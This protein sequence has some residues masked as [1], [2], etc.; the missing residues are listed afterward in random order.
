MLAPPPAGF[1]GLASPESGRH[2]YTAGMQQPTA[3]PVPR[4]GPFWARALHGL[5]APRLAIGL[6]L[7]FVL[8][9]F[10]WGP[11][12]YVRRGLPL[13]TAALYL[14]L[15]FLARAVWLVPTV[16]L[17]LAAYNLTSGWQKPRR[18][19]LVALVLAAACFA[20]P[21]TFWIDAIAYLGSLDRY[22]Y[23]WA[24]WMYSYV[25][26]GSMLGMLILVTRDQE[27]ARELAAEELR[28]IEQDQAHKA[29]R[30]QAAQAQIEPHFL[31]NTLANVKRLYLL[32][33]PAGR[34]MLRNLSQVLGSALGQMRDE[35]CTLE[36]E[37]GLSLAYLR[38]QEIRMGDR[39]K[40]ETRVPASLH[41]A[42]LPSMM[43]STLVENAIKHG[44]APLT[45]GGTVCIEAEAAGGV[46]QVKV[47]DTGRGLVQG[48]G[49]G[50]G[51]ANIEARLAAEFGGEAQFTLEEMPSGGTLAM[52]ALPLQLVRS[53]SNAD[54]RVPA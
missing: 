51:L 19:G 42:L 31:F 17:S 45:G 18:L 46:L 34:S 32:D 38:V 3:N 16:L 43:L 9:V 10:S 2:R 6:L 33:A 36:R 40:V 26:A 49:T 20:K 15:T 13:D 47:S 7:L 52:I 44:I 1:V 41:A 11:V 54:D 37:V 12:A 14:G 35:H 39:L 28:Q 30:L 27:A 24:H 21:L 23:A 50:V 8:C 29:A 5:T 53:S 4:F 48:G 25:V 22:E